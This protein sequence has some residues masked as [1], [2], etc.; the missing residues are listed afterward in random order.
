[1]KIKALILLLTSMLLLPI[2]FVKAGS[3]CDTDLDSD[4]FNDQTST[5]QVLSHAKGKI[6]V[7]NKDIALM[8]K[9][10]Y[11]ESKG[12]P[13]EGKVAVASVILNRV[14]DSSFPKSI[15]GVIKQPSAFSCVSRNGQIT[16]TPDKA[17][18]NAVMEALNGADPTNEALFFYNP[19]I[20][21]SS[22]MKNI[23]KTNLKT[24]GN[25]VFFTAR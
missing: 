8:A 11:A 20:A 6:Y 22:W 24:I 16:V 1:M 17:S 5:V 25:H 21:T 12:E 15:E 14:K 9:V 2:N 10:V 7:T 19:R 23:G 13:Y 18:Y 4:L 3:A